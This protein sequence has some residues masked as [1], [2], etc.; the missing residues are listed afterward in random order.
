M[1]AIVKMLESKVLRYVVFFAGL[2]GV[3][4]GAS[5]GLE[6][7][8]GGGLLLV[9]FALPYVRDT[10]IAKATKAMLAALDEPD[11][12]AEAK[13]LRNTTSAVKLARLFNGHSPKA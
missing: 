9:G 2:A 10:K 13:A 4:L 3:G 6:W 1:S 8:S 12:P 7:L 11:M 5:L